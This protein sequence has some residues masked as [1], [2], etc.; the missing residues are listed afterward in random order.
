MAWV[1]DSIL[2]ISTFLFALCGTGVAYYSLKR[3]HLLDTPEERSNHTVPTPHGGGL[4]VMVTVVCFQVVIGSPLLLIL[5]SLLLMGI[6]FWDDVKNLPPSWRLLVQFVIVALVLVNDYEGKV[7]PDFIP[8]WLELPI[9]AVAWVWFI[10]LF[11][12][13]DGSDGLA[14][15]ETISICT[16][17]F[18]LSWSVSLPHDAFLNCVILTGS[19]LGFAV[20]NWHPAKIFLGDAGSVPLGFLLGFMLISLAGH[21]YWQAALILPAYFITDATLVLARRL[22]QGKKIWQAHSEHFY[23]RAIRKGMAHDEVAKRVIALN[24][25]LIVL[26]VISTVNPMMAYLSLAA[27]YMA[28]LA[29]LHRFTRATAEVLQPA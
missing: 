27:A 9:L 10:N 22:L 20:W 1:Y 7:F 28:T 14:A 6:S 12:F 19:L 15:S 11:N 21:G 17:L 4:G 16:G 2:F 18:I 29:L 8:H 13:M 26:T 23:Q 3:A 5:G 25:I 24:I